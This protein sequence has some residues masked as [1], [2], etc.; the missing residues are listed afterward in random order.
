MKALIEGVWQPQVT[1]TATYQR[2]RAKQPEGLFRNWVTA[3]P[4]T[5]FSAEPGRYHLYASYACPFAHRTLLYRRLLGLED[6]LPLSVL[7]PRWGGP[8]GWT[9]A[10]DPAFP[11]VTVDPVNGASALW[12]LYVEVRPNHTGKVTV[13]LLWDTREGTIV[14]D[15]SADIMRM[16]DLAFAGLRDNRLTFYPA[17]LRDEIDELGGFIRRRVNGGVYRAGFA[18]DQAAFDEAIADFFA[19]L[20]QL[21]QR[22]SDGR[23]YLLGETATEVDC[24]LFPTLVRLDAAYA[25]ALKVNARRLTDY[26]HLDRH[27]H[28]LYAWPGVAETVKLDHVKRHY[29][30]DLGV[31]NPGIVPPGPATPFEVAA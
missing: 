6:V 4:G 3:D 15:E 29:Y 2:A 12:Q 27:T 28:R 5:R 26:P 8:E 25:G 19:A 22:L 7:H 21:E 1:D 11:E 10:P 23:P 14:S 30:D 24:L 9:F 31:T 20:D 18:A 17:R 13:P 16:L